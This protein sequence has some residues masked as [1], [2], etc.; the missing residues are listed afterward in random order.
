MCFAFWAPEPALDAQIERDTVVKGTSGVSDQAAAN[1]VSLSVK[2]LENPD[3]AKI[4][5]LTIGHYF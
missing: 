1:L 5:L 3:R 2:K 4:P